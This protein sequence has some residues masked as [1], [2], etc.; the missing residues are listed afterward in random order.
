MG[1]QIF[2]WAGGAGLRM[3]NR[4]MWVRN[5]HSCWATV[6]DMKSTSWRHLTNLFLISH[7]F[8]TKQAVCQQQLYG[9]LV[10]KSH[11]AVD[12]SEMSPLSHF[13][14]HLQKVKTVSELVQYL[15]AR[16]LFTCAG[17]LPGRPRHA[18]EYF[19]SRVMHFVEGSLWICRE[20][21][22]L[23]SCCTGGRALALPQSRFT[24]ELFVVSFTVSVFDLLGGWHW[25]MYD[26]KAYLR[27]LEG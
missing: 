2:L 17:P 9:R 22:H 27:Q 7:Q 16:S 25:I 24:T 3:E 13:G 20:T 14:I 1:S 6:E 12:R 5:A 21:S 4:L 26:E 23:F 11:M 10:A 19:T 15:A 18:S 8:P